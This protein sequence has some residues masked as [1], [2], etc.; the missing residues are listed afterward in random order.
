MEQL[1]SWTSVAVELKCDEYHLAE[2]YPITLAMEPSMQL[3]FEQFWVADQN[4]N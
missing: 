3:I 2:S 4:M 1:A